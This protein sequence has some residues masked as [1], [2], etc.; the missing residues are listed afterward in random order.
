MQYRHYILYS[1]TC[2]L[3][4]L[5][6]ALVCRC[7]CG[8][9]ENQ[10]GKLTTVQEENEEVEIANDAAEESADDSLPEDEFET[11]EKVKFVKSQGWFKVNVCTVVQNAAMITI[12]NPL[13]KDLSEIH[14]T[15]RRTSISD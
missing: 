6:Y 2:C 11:D 3:L 5:R 12:I 4:L 8:R 13:H 1:C 9:P 15:L 10:H 14:C 7:C